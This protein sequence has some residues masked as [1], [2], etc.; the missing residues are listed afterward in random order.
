MNQEV[1][2]LDNNNLLRSHTNKMR[3]VATTVDR[4]AAVNSTPATEFIDGNGVELLVSGVSMIK[5]HQY[6]VKQKQVA[7]AT[8][9]ELG[10][11]V[12]G[13]YQSIYVK[14]TAAVTATLIGYEET[15]ETPS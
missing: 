7:D 12:L 8:T 10:G 13:S 9:F 3:P 6:I 5:E 1:R 15:A 11:L 4:I 14:S 2:V